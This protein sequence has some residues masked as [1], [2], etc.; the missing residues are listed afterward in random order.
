MVISNIYLFLDELAA[1][2]AVTHALPKDQKTNTVP[3]RPRAENQRTVSIV[4]NV[5]PVQAASSAGVSTSRKP[6]E[7]PSPDTSNYGRRHVGT[8]RPMKRRTPS[9]T[10]VCFKNNFYWGMGP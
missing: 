4:E 7:A 9:P 3:G 6:I 2:I 8:V 1:A 5:I 10:E